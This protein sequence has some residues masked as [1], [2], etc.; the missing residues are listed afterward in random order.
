MADATISNQVKQQQLLDASSDV[1]N[2]MISIMKKGLELKKLPY[3]KIDTT[4]SNKVVGIIGSLEKGGSIALSIAQKQYSASVSQLVQLLDELLNKG[5]EN[6]KKT[7]KKVLKYGT[8]MA[9]IVEA[10]SPEQAQKAIEAVALPPGSYTIKRESR[11]SVALNGYVGVFA[12]DEYILNV[13]DKRWINN[14][15]VTAPVGISVSWG[16][17]CP[18][19]MRPWSIG[20]F[21]PIIDLGAVASYRFGNA[22]DTVNGAETIPTIQLKDIVAPG[23][24]LEIGIG[25]T[26]LSFAVGRQFGSRLRKIE[27]ESGKVGD[28]YQRLGATLKV[29]IPIVHFYASPGKK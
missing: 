10:D 3:I 6:N 14:V 9:N 8:F 4:I 17:I 15:A 18:D 21:A 26:P 11:F 25:G 22:E 28:T 29:D 16:N 1:F 12:G 13:H 24:F 19:M 27:N 5:D 20:L 7:L 2:G 23:I